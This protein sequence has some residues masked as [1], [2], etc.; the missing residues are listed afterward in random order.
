MF[1]A[2]IFEAIM[3]GEAVLLAPSQRTKVVCEKPKSGSKKTNN[4]N[5]FFIGQGVFVLI[6]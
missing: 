5:N 4:K 6:G 1:P 2:E 3:Y